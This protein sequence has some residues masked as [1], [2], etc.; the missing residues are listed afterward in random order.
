MRSSKRSIVTKYK[1]EKIKSYNYQSED[2]ENKKEGLPCPLLVSP[3][4]GTAA[5]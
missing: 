2:A 4:P 1:D 5:R 3:C